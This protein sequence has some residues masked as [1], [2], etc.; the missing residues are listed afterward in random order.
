MKY[1]NPISLVTKWEANEKKKKYACRKMGLLCA[2]LRW[3]HKFYT[4]QAK[5]FTLRL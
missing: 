2:H 5:P 3:S 4:C 1:A